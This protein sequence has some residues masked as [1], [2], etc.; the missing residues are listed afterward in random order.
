M[1]GRIRSAR[2]L[3]L[4]FF[5]CLLSLKHASVDACR[6]SWLIDSNRIATKIRSASGTIDPKKV[7]WKSNPTRTCP[8]CQH[9]IDSSEIYCTRQYH[10][11][12]PF[13]IL[14]Y[15]FPFIK[16][17][18]RKDCLIVVQQWPGLPQGVK[19]DPSYQ[20]IIWHLLAKNGHEGFF[21]HPFIDEFIRIVHEDVGICYTHPR[22]LPG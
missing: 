5:I 19:F 20:E 17:M 2:K 18:L 6:P 9:V 16:F 8:S 7:D 4:D 14:Y 22:N 11:P 21:S 15:Q 10:F 12:K 13:C 1:K 3:D